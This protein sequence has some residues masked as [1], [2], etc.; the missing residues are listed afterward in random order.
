MKLD[1]IARLH[2]ESFTTPRPWTKIE[3]A[4]LLNNPNVFLCEVDYGF[5]LGRIAGVESELLTMAVE[6]KHRRIGLGRTLIFKFQQQ[7]IKRGANE[8]FLEVSQENSS[9]IA[10]YNYMGFQ[11]NGLRKNYYKTPNATKIHALV[12][13]KYLYED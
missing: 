8:L 12:M 10:L 3:F 13:K 1:V 2:S 6:S 7:A 5:L 4:E 9:A 11:K